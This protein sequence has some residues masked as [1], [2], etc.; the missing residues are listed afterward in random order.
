[1][2]R[3][4]NVKGNGNSQVKYFIKTIKPKTNC[5]QGGKLSKFYFESHD[6]KSPLYL[7]ADLTVMMLAG[8]GPA[9]K[10]SIW[11]MYVYVCECVCGLGGW[12]VICLLLLT[13][14]F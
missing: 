1:M 14:V 4:F 9:R 12:V 5:Q 8:P 13:C 10:A 11:C 3:K 6:R 2:E 7:P